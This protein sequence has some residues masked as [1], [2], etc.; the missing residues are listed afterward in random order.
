MKHIY[1]VL[2]LSIIITSCGD[3]KKKSVED[4]YE[5]VQEKSSYTETQ[6][7]EIEVSM[8]NERDNNVQ[9]ETNDAMTIADLSN[10]DVSS[11]ALVMLEQLSE[12]EQMSDA[13]E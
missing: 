12:D 7:K 13:K 10:D 4:I 9:I 11:D 5:S 8:G 6:D 3:D 2:V 1:S